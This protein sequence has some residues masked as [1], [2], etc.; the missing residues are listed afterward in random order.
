MRVLIAM[1]GLCLCATA[2][3]LEGR[4]DRI[5]LERRLLVVNDSAYALPPE[6]VVRS[7]AGY[8]MPLSSLREGVWLSLELDGGGPARVRA[9]Q[10]LNAP[11]SWRE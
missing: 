7:A 5:D 6:V 4:L 2:Q 8:S 1:L 3:A 10:V 11:T 9:I